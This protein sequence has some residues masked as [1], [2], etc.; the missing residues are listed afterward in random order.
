MLQEAELTT[1]AL[2]LVLG[3]MEKDEPGAGLPDGALGVWE[4]W[5]T[6]VMAG[7]EGC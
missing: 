3:G 2:L 6:F 7:V 4:T 1:I 5:L